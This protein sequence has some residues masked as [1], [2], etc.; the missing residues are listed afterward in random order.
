MFLSILRETRKIHPVTR[1]VHWTSSKIGLTWP[2]IRNGRNLLRYDRTLLLEECNVPYTQI[3]TVPSSCAHIS[4]PTIIISSYNHKLC[5]ICFKKQKLRRYW[6]YSNESP[7]CRVYACFARV[8]IC[9]TG[10]VLGVA[11]TGR[12]DRTPAVPSG[13]YWR[14]VHDQL[15]IWLNRRRSLLVELVVMW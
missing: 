12:D 6:T 14:F 3:P 5:T 15:K 9:V 13:A 1:I 10:K 2:S 7:S 4:L 11:R 8:W